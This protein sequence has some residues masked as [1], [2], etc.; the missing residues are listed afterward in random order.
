MMERELE[1]FVKN[2]MNPKENMTI[3]TL[4]SF[5]NFDPKTNVAHVSEEVQIHRKSGLFQIYDHGMMIAEIKDFV[6]INLPKE[7][8][9][10]RENIHN[11]ALYT[12]NGLQSEG[13]ID[14]RAS[15]RK[16]FQELFLQ[17]SDISM[18]QKFEPPAFG[19]TVLGGSHGFDP[20]GSTSG[21]LLW[22]DGR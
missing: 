12:S 13:P 14:P 19:V 21:Y 7:L 22:I 18:E 5:I 6:E 10:S 20:K 16:S 11:A 2:P 1:F 15:Q 8:L 4:I 9:L 17:E 3:D